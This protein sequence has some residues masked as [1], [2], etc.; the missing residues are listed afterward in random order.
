MVALAAVDDILRF[1]MIITNDEAALRVNCQDVSLDEVDNLKDTLFKELDYANKLG[2]GGVGLAAPQIGIPK[3][4]AV[5][6]F[7]K[8]TDFS[9]VLVN[10]KIENGYD[11]HLFKQEGCLSFPGK[12]ENT[13]RFGEIY[14]TNNLIYPHSFIVTGLLAVVCQHEIDHFNGVIFTDRLQKPISKKLGP[15]DLC[16]CGSMKKF[17]K[18]CG[19]NI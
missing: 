11:L 1:N 12:S 14:V 3:K 13:L 2:K 18:C 15:N 17:K 9:L 16:S 4:I 19:R 5:I 7:D 6:K 8:I 10:C